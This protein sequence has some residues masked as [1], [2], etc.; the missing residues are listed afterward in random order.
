VAPAGNAIAENARI[1]A[2]GKK[3]HLKGFEN[4]TGF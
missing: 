3:I 4:V 2:S 1:F